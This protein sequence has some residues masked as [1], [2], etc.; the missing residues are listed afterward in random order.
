MAATQTH[1]QNT[2]THTGTGISNN[3]GSYREMAAATA[4]PLNAER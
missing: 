1:A 4:F 2:H 3:G